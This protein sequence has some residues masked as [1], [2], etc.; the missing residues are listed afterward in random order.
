[1]V[2]VVETATA[3][4]WQGAEYLVTA[5][6]NDISTPKSAPYPSVFSTFDFETCFAPQWR[7]LF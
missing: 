2:V 5:T 4:F 7:P 3:H 6:Q 1:M